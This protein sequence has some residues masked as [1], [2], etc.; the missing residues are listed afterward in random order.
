MSKKGEN[1]VEILLVGLVIILAGWYLN[2][3]Q[4]AEWEERFKGLETQIQGLQ[5]EFQTIKTRFGN[6]E[7]TMEGTKNTYEPTKQLLVKEFREATAEVKNEFSIMQVRQSTLEKK[8]IGLKRET[9]VIL[10]QPLKVEWVKPE[11]KKLLEKAGIAKKSK[12]L[13]N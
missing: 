6:I 9:T 10:S 11:H 12:T 5:S 3:R 1:K 4:S 7:T 8:I 13:D 2:L